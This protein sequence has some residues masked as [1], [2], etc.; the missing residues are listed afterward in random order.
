MCFKGNALL[1]EK[2]HHLGHR[3]YSTLPQNLTMIAMIYNVLENNLSS[4]Q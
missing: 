4:Y 2:G 3:A 1:N